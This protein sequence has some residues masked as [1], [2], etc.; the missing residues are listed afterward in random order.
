M[1]YRFNDENGR[2]LSERLGVNCS[3]DLF[4]IDVV[5]VFGILFLLC[6]NLPLPFLRND[7]ENGEATFVDDDDDELV[8]AVDEAESFNIVSPS[9][10][11]VFKL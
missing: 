8:D 5:D 9:S 3:R 6:E 7:G 11:V 10:S 1:Y 4:E 2:C